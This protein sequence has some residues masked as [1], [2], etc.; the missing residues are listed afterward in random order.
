MTNTIEEI[1]T[2]SVLSLVAYKDFP[3]TLNNWGQSEPAT[4]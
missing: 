3:Q 4:V 2:G 1:A